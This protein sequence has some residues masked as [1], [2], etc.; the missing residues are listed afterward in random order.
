MRLGVF[1][2]SFDP[3][4]RGHLQLAE[5]ALQQARLDRVVLIPAAKQPL[6]PS[7]PHAS[8]ADRLAMLRLAIDAQPQL[9]VE[10]LELERGGVSY[11]YETLQ[12]L[13]ERHPGAELWLLIGADAVAELPQW[14]EPARILALATP[15]IAARPGHPWPDLSPLASLVGPERLE[16]IASARQRMPPCDVSSSDI[17]RRIAAGQPWRALTDPAV[18]DYIEVRGLYGA[19]AMPLA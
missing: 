8:D 6:K 7:G 14:R 4:H 5:T 15:L 11:T 19:A 1:G 18:A 10:P 17:R 12:S 9:A 16:A 13:A 2:G 3:V